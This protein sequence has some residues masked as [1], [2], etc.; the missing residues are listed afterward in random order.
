MMTNG[1]KFKPCEV[2]VTSKSEVEI[3]LKES[4]SNRK[5]AVTNLNLHSSRS[6]CLYQLKIKAFKPRLNSDEPPELFD[7]VLNMI[8]LAGSENSKTAGVNGERLEECKSINLSLSSLQLVFKAIKNQEAHIPYR[9]SK[10]TQLL[11]NYLTKDTKALMIV[12][13]S[14]LNS[15]YH[16]C[17]HTLKF[18]RQVNQ[19][20]LN[21]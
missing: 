15:N 4:Y 13:V 3:I 9:N 18:A 8:D 16:E 1:V 11:Q 12:N 5:Q 17:L 10:L 21:K 14:P 7:G 2:E 20:K 19:C 6:H